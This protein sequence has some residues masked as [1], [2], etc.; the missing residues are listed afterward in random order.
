MPS[1]SYPS[2]RGAT[3]VGRA[4]RSG[5][6]GRAGWSFT[7]Q[8]LSSLANAA[9]SILMAKATGV[10]GYGA[11]AVAFTVYTFLIGVS[12]ALVN[13]PY[14]MRFA[15]VP[16]AEALAGARGGTGAGLL[17]GL[18]LDRKSVV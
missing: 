9:L 17:L 12:R 6:V 5:V 4:L 10:A 13:Q 15:A 16:D 2:A 8:A 14:L 11:F 18:A 7:D 1:R 3:L